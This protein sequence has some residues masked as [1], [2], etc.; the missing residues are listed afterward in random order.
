VLNID[1]LT[2]G[3]E[4]KTVLHE[5]TLDVSDGEIV[6]LL[7]ANGSGKSTLLM[8]VS[9]IIKAKAGRI[10]FDQKALHELKPHEIVNEGIIQVP[11]GR[12]LF[13]Q[14]TV[15]ENLAIASMNPRAKLKR[16]VNLRVVLEIFPA[17]EKRR[18]QKAATLSGGEQQMLSVARGL[19]AEPRILLLDEPSWGLAP[20]LVMNIFDALADLNRRG[21]SLLVVEQNASLAIDVCSRGYVM[22]NGRIVLSGTSQQLL[23]SDLVR[24]AYLGI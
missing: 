2:S 24:K 18:A 20:L 21:M 23:E 19:M 5:V 17:L 13:P 12:R 15:D 6:A 14:L 16:E 7:G 3:Y 8:T 1:T 11:E 10:T 9:G 4:G 22:E